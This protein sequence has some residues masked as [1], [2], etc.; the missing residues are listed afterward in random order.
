VK[1]NEEVKMD[2]V[3]TELKIRIV[4]EKSCSFPVS[5]SHDENVSRLFFWLHV[6]LSRFR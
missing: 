6:E 4:C 5:A 1:Q 3:V 2:E